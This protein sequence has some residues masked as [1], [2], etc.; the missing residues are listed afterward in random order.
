MLN[1]YIHKLCT[2]K[3][4]TYSVNSIG[5]NAKATSTD[6]DVMLKVSGGDVYGNENGKVT[7]N[8]VITARGFYHDLKNVTINDEVVVDGINHI[9][10][11]INR[12]RR[13]ELTLTLKRNG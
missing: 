1:A 9:V 11:S 10:A 4:Y 5:M 7:V 8:S 3:H 12:N 2:I 6:S 13:N